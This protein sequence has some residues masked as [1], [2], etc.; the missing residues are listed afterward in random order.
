[1]LLGLTNVAGSLP[2]VI[3]V[4]SVGILVSGAFLLAATP[5]QAQV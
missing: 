4:A 1:V 3:G 5:C 2:G